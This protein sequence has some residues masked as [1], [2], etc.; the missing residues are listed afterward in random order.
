MEQLFSTAK[1][2]IRMVPKKKGERVRDL[3][4]DKSGLFQIIYADPPW[5][6]RDKVFDPAKKTAHSWAERYY[7]TMRVEEICDLQP[8]RIA[9]RDCLLFIWVTGPCLDSA[10]EVI[11]AWGFKYATIAFVWDKQRVNVGHYTMSSTEMCLVAK[12]GRIPKPRGARNV[13]QL[14]SKKA[15]AHSAKPNEVRLRIEEMFPLQRKIELFARGEPAEGWFAWGN[16]V[17]EHERQD[18]VQDA[19][20]DSEG[21]EQG[22]K[23][24]LWSRSVR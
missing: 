1:R 2:V 14:L 17:T 13:R 15:S 20:R 23:A 6:Y 9:D 5:T 11:S 21:T 12:R 4:P 18:Q 8:Q 7:E 10:F 22:H 19:E 24:E 16:E 3:D